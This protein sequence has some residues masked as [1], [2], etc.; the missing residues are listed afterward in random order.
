MK[1]VVIRLIVTFLLII[2]L[3]TFARVMAI[4][5]FGHGIAP[6]VSDVASV[7]ILLLLWM[8][9]LGE[10]FTFF[11]KGRKKTEPLSSGEAQSERKE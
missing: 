9:K 1:K 6:V 5:L 10:L 7:G 11:S 2:P 4:E 8:G 3:A